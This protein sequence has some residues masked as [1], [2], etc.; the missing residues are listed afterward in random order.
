MSIL[1]STGQLRALEH[2]TNYVDDEIDVGY[3]YAADKT[4]K[5]LYRKYFK[6]YISFHLQHFWITKLNFVFVVYRYLQHFRTINKISFKH[7]E[8]FQAF[9]SNF[10]SFLK[11]QEEALDYR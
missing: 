10:L 6:N 8:H 3:D 9:F 2:D 7:L 4:L 11:Y 5:V 1:P